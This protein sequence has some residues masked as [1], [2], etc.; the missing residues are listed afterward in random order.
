MEK[1][2]LILFPAI[3]RLEAQIAGNHPMEVMIQSPIAAMEDDHETAGVLIKEIRTLSNNYTPPDFACP[4]F[5]VTFQK[6]KEFDNDLMKHI[7][8]ENNI[9]FQR[10]KR[11]VSPSNCSL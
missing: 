8:L 3:R 2:E 4:T 5:R 9:L 10:F 11:T 7:H 1:E 6:L